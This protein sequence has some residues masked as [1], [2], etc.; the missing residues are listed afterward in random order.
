MEN[1]IEELGGTAAV[2][3][4]VE[5][6]YGRIYEDEELAP[7]FENADYVRLREMQFEF[8]VAA[9]G[10]TARYSGAGL[11]A[12]HA[13]RGITPKHYTK[14]VGHLIGALEDRGTEKRV[15]DWIVSQLAMY[16]DKIT[17]GANVD[18]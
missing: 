10:G 11:Q 4:I 1:A 16:R 5:D 14:F 12:I 6:M 2:Y 7:F 3:A 15:I 8:M 9:L 13:N 18:G 17:G